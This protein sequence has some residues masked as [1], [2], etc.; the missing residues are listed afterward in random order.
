MVHLGLGGQQVHSLVAESV[1]VCES[2][3]LTS[4]TFFSILHQK[5]LQF[6]KTY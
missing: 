6:M 5:K 4:L 1:F 3:A 2:P